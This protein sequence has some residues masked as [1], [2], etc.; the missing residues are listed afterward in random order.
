MAHLSL[1]LDGPDEAGQPIVGRLS[2]D[3]SETVT[4]EALTLQLVFQGEASGA[5]CGEVLDTLELGQARWRAG[6]SCEYP[7]EFQPLRARWGYDDDGFVARLSLLARARLPGTAGQHEARLP[8]AQPLGIETRRLVVETR[9]AASA[10]AVEERTPAGCSLLWAAGALIGLLGGGYL[11]SSAWLIAGAIVLFLGLVFLW[12]LV[13]WLGDVREERALGRVQ[14]ELTTQR[15]EDYRSG[16]SSHLEGQVWFAERAR[17]TRVSASLRVVLSAYHKQ[18]RRKPARE[19]EREL[20]RRSADA[21]R[22][23]DSGS[24]T[25][26][27]PAPEIDPAPPAFQLSRREGPDARQQVAA[28]WLLE[29]DVRTADNQSFQLVRDLRVRLPEA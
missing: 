5:L 20:S 7:F 28:R 11:L 23:G 10:K 29:L 24:W 13:L 9:Q 15:S 2:V 14:I 22:D 4:C 25:F 1:H 6:E 16:D 27:L 8:L 17:P 18:R 3:P 26:H 19:L 12:V 21:S